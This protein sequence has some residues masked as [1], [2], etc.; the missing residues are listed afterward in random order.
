MRLRVVHHADKAPLT[1][2]VHQFT[3]LDAAVYTDEWN[4]YVG[5]NRCHATVC[6]GQRQWAR[7]ADGVREVHTN[8]IEGV[9]TTVRNFLRPFRGG[10]RSCLPGMLPYVSFASILNGL[11]VSLSQNLSL[12]LTLNMS[13]SSKSSQWN[14]RPSGRE[15]NCASY[16][17]IEF[18]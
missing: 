4:G 10:T 2:H 17:K 15:G 12:A 16:P 13:L 11:P 8:T 3:E 14:P 1:A 18:R 9:W 7:D 6:Q 5:L